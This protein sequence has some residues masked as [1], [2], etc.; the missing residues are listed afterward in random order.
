ML[1]KIFYIISL[2]FSPLFFYISNKIDRIKVIFYKRDFI[3]I[4]Y[5]IIFALFLYALS[6]KE[7]FILFFILLS[8]LWIIIFEI[9]TAEI[10]KINLKFLNYIK[11]LVLQKDSLKEMFENFDCELK[12]Y[13][14]QLNRYTSLFSLV[15][16]INENVEIEKIVKEFYTK[17]I[18]HFGE[19]KISYLSLVKYKRKDII[20]CIEYPLHKEDIL[21]LFKEYLTKKQLSFGEEQIQNLLIYKIYSNNY[22]YAIL[23]EYGKEYEE[24]LSDLNFF[25]D[26]TKIGFIRAI[27]FSE[28]EEMS[29]IDGLTELYLRRYF[30]QR[31]ENEILRA[32]RYNTNFSLVMIDVD[33][34]KKIN[35]N[36]GHL[37]GDFVLKNLA[38]VIKE[39][40]GKQGICCRWG[41]EEFLILIPYQSLNSVKD[42]IEELR[43]KVETMDFQ[44]EDKIIKITISCGISYFPLAGKDIETLINE[45]DRKM[46]KAKQS[47]RNKVVV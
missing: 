3:F 44:Y 42:L 43:K 40:V 32:E 38:E 12:E 18:S 13:Q 23:V 24:V 10:K 30:L 9:H 33:F 27:L 16:E 7:V 29:R 39:M 21:C 31:L 46:Y 34:F 36:Y 26:E 28:I 22:E 17:L 20:D 4:I 47:G 6:V 35:D 8:F 1:D 14:R 2:S 11:T 25:I 15:H 37:V 45:A 5:I 41:G 19:N